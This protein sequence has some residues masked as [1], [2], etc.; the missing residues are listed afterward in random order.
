MLL[1]TEFL[2]ALSVSFVGTGSSVPV[3]V[4][5]EESMLPVIGRPRRGPKSAHSHRNTASSQQ[6]T[7]ESSSGFCVERHVRF[8]RSPDV[9]E[10]NGE[11]ACDGYNSSVLSLLASA[12]TQM[13]A[14]RRREESSPRGRRMWLAHSI[15]RLRKYTLPAFVIPSG[16]SRSPD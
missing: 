10:Q 8:L 11:L 2:F 5:V 6:I 4:S 9:M 13:E 7:R 14:P 15:S 1:S 3:G 16:G 12:I